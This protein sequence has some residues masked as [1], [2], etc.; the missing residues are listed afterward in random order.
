MDETK[1][2]PGVQATASL[3]ERLLDLLIGSQGPTRGKY[4][5]AAAVV[6]GLTLVNLGIEWLVRDVEPISLAMVY[7][8]GVALCAARLGRWPGLLSSVLSVMMFNFALIEPRMT[9]VVHDAQYMI[10]FAVMLLV[11]MLIGELA[12][13]VHEQAD[14]ARER[15]S[16]TQSLAQ[17]ADGLAVHNEPG[18]IAQAFADRLALMFEAQVTVYLP[19]P[20]SE[21]VACA[22][23]TL[24]ELLTDPHE[25]GVAQWAWD[26]AENAGLG[27]ENL[28]GS[29]CLHVPGDKA[30][31]NGPVV[32][33]LP[34]ETD[35]AF[36]PT[37]LALI[38][39]CV[40]VL[41]TALER[42]RLAVETRSALVEAQ[43]ERLRGSLLSSVSHDLRTPLAVIAGTSESLLARQR[44]PASAEA[45]GLGLICDQSRRLASLVE[46][47]LSVTKLQSGS[48]H[49]GLQWVPVDELVAGALGR[50]PDG[51]R[52]KLVGASGEAQVFADPVLMEQ[53]VYNLL[54]NALKYA[55]EG[56]PVRVEAGTRDR[57]FRLSVSDAGPGV[58]EAER[59]R[60]F[61]KF[62]RGANAGTLPGVGLGLAICQ[63][64]ASLHHG[65]ITCRG[66]VFELVLPQP[67]EPMVEEG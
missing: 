1:F 53:L 26:Q 49:A 19:V 61:E 58:P 20:Q 41:A 60:V 43:A 23:S 67:A 37:Q 39:A 2:K 57:L 42:A 28:P 63:A 34:K 15:L 30:T 3:R 4:W 18:A 59:E 32:A 10:T 29:R 66:A 14:E 16:Q 11:A 46:N 7:L 35:E 13:R 62:V 22:A 12:G 27:T 6:L 24:P 5:Q 51:G 45:Q 44:D 21:K 65:S 25:L 47:I 40:A 56:T 54:E 48:V 50:L 52:V 8:L 17:L 36:D 55:P 38:E 33:L 31:G 64:I 9:F